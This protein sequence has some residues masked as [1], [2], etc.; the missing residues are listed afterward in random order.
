[1]ALETITLDEAH[2]RLI[3]HFKATRPGDDVKPGSYNW[4]LCRTIAAGLTGNQAQLVATK[5]D[6]LPDTAEGIELER[7]ANIRGVYKKGATGARKS[8]ALRVVGTAA[9]N[10]PDSTAL[11]HPESQLTFRTSGASV[12]GSQNG[13]TGWVDVDV[14]AVSTG[15]Q[16]RLAAGAILRFTTP[17]AGI[18]EDAE[19]QLDL[20]E[21]GEDQESDGALRLRVL[22]RFRSPPLGGAAEDYVQWAL[23]EPGIA[24]AYAYPL[25]NGVGSVDVTA[26]HAGSG[27]V[28]VLSEGERAL[29]EQEINAKRPIGVT[30]RV[31]T[32][33]PEA[34]LVEYAYVPDGEPEHEPDWDDTSPPTVLSWDAGTRK[35]RFTGGSRPATMKAGDRIVIK[36]A[37][38]TGRERVIEALTDTVGVQDAVILETDATGDVP[39]A[40]DVIYAGG[41]LVEPIREAIQALSDSLGTANP[42]VNKLGGRYGSWEGNLRLNAIGRVATGVDGVLDGDLIA[43][44]ATQEADDPAYPDDDEIGLLYASRIIVRRKH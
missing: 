23:E 43:P 13:A 20:D 27:A 17:I 31:L 40:A 7:W 24:A 6:L 38:G 25:R 18:E 26:L 37:L 16:T 12:V 21:D 22:S 30:F 4:L 2:D 5:N 1:M 15:S 28:R 8:D 9:T 42:D 35:L 33:V 32:V 39:V 34:V 41:P 10:V 29:L 14:V 3:A 36:T 19:L 44:V 11:Y